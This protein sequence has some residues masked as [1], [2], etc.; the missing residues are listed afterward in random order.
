M[1]AVGAE[2][3]FVA[4]EERE[5]AVVVPV[6]V[7]ELAAIYREAF[8]AFHALGIPLHV[9]VLYPFVAPDALGDVLPR[10]AAVLADRGRFDYRLT[11][12]RTFPRTVWLAPEPA[13]AFVRVT[14]AIEAAFPQAPHWGGVFEEVIPHATL[15]DGLGEAEVE[16]TV[17]RLRPLVEPLLPVT[18]V[19]DE[20]V[21]LAEQDDGR[22]IAAARLPLG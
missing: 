18:L 12:L 20:A 4:A 7:P 16:E 5:T 22:W 11:S 8:P 6:D 19:A 14:R 1:A 3:S 9:T 21:V 2:P 13:E 17:R 15:V 10:L